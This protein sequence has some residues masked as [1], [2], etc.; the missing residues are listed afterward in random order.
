MSDIL[1]EICPK[2]IPD[3][4]IDVLIEVGSSIND[5][6]STDGRDNIILLPHPIKFLQGRKEGIS[7]G[8]SGTSPC[9]VPSQLLAL[10]SFDVLYILC[11][12]RLCLLLSINDYCVFHVQWNC[13]LLQLFLSYFFEWTCSLENLHF[14]YTNRIFRLFFFSIHISKLFI[15]E[16]LVRK[17]KWYLELKK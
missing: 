8:N 16:N 11:F 4:C 17:H 14:L 10:V 2:L 5:I 3:A 6:Q 7:C 9:W 12:D 15:L 13:Q 1:Q